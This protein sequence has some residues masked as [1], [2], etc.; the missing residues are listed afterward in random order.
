MKHDIKFWWWERIT[1]ILILPISLYLLV[2][3]LFNLKRPQT[4]S[5]LEP[6]DQG[7]YSDAFMVLTELILQHPF[8]IIIF[9]LLA[10]Y[11]GTLGMQVITEDYVSQPLL[12]NILISALYAGAFL[13]GLAG[14][15]SI[16]SLIF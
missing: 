10:L 11:H 4:K 13:T 14:L 7:S 9:M 12:M 5:I 1:A 6:R 16:F 15:F 8:L 2:A 3:L